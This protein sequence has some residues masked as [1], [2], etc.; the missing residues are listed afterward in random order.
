ME[1]VAVG[2]RFPDGTKCNFVHFGSPRSSPAPVAHAHT[3]QRT[4]SAHL[5]VPKRCV[6]MVVSCSS[7][8]V[9][10][11]CAQSTCRKHCRRLGGCHLFDHVG[12]PNGAEGLELKDDP[13]LPLCDL[14]DDESHIP[15]SIEHLSHSPSPQLHGV[16][17]VA[18]IVEAHIEH[19]PDDLQAKKPTR[20]RTIPA[21][22]RPSPEDGPCYHMQMP[23]VFTAQ[24]A[25][26][27]KREEEQ[28]QRCADEIEAQNRARYHT[29]VYSWVTDVGQPNVFE[30][31][32]GTSS[33]TWPH[34]SL[35]QQVISMMGLAA[36][37]VNEGVGAT[38]VIH[39]WNH[40]RRE[41]QGVQP[42]YLITV[43]E[44]QPVLLKNP[45]VTQCVDL[46]SFREELHQHHN[47]LPAPNE[48]VFHAHSRSQPRHTQDDVKMSALPSEL[49][50]EALLL[51][52]GKGKAKHLSEASPSPPPAK[53]CSRQ[54]SLSYSAYS[55]SSFG[56]PSPPPKPSKRNI[57]CRSPHSP[58]TSV[59][60]SPPHTHC[61][62]LEWATVRPLTGSSRAHA[63]ISGG[64]HSDLID[65]DN[66][67]KIWPGDFYTCDIAKGFRLCETI[68]KCRQGVAKVFQK[69]FGVPYASTTFHA[70]K[71][72][73]ADA[74]ANI[75]DRFVKAGRTEDG[76]WSKFM[77]ETRS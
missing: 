58:T 63:A 69:M 73:W 56:T 24:L 60:S 7:T 17:S 15:A 36:A 30:F 28:R 20:A 26:T 3:R 16:S 8:R 14:G 38:S 6:C 31:Q 70:H 42:D 52:K 4:R 72:R 48:V 71:K 40:R 34:L 32:S 54:P 49:E 22:N 25:E 74:P 64:T 47:V 43:V 35:N 53:P 61:K 18:P 13:G 1:T 75:T 29:V 2:K 51:S 37:R 76:L 21:H 41:W 12:D 67:V 46:D 55:I 62:P 33:F 23:E 66:D 10:K 68:S 45:N 57:R 5:P 44:G 9:N 77:A 50:V 27:S 11:N 65:V 19:P 59:D 39:V